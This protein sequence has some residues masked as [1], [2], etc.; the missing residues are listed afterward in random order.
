ML[1]GLSRYVSR[2]KGVTVSTRQ[3][4]QLGVEGGVGGKSQGLWEASMGQK[5]GLVGGDWRSK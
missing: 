3:E 1:L 2:G 5:R 4:E